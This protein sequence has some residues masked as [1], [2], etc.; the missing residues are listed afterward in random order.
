MKIYSG[1]GDKNLKS[2]PRSIAVGI[3]D[4]VHRGH[5]KILR[6]MLVRAKSRRRRSIIVTFDPHPMK[7]LAHDPKISILMS[8]RHRLRV[9]GKT[10]AD[11]TLVI[12][13]N[14]AF[15]KISAGAFLKNILIK[16]LGMKSLCVGHDFRFGHKGLGDLA[17]LKSMARRLGFRLSVIPAL[18][19]SGEII[20]STRV[21]R[22][23][24][25][26]ELRKAERMLGRPVSVYGDVVPGRGR[27]R[28]LG[29]PTAN[30]NPHHETLPPSGVYAVK[31]YWRNRLLKGVVHL[32]ARPTFGEKDRSVEVHLL[33]FHK[34]IYGEELELLF[35]KKLRGIKKFK[36]RQELSRRIRLDIRQASLLL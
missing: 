21:R 29:F 31:A 22:L 12:P 19:K 32:G 36:S 26:G 10:G 27:G 16:K 14:K 17:F 24:E 3:F 28:G 8:L 20:S 33:N 6:C 9:F 23:I 4:G 18:K 35:M 15:S 34:N 13:F 30:L 11:E 25:K 2:R 1:I 5:Q 7:V